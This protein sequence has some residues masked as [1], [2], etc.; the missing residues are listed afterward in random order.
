MKHLRLN[1]VAIWR[2]KP[3]D[4]LTVR[5]NPIGRAYEDN[6]IIKKTEKVAYRYAKNYEKG[7][8]KFCLF[9]FTY[10]ESVKAVEKFLDKTA[11]SITVAKIE[12]NI[13]TQDFDWLNIKY[14]ESK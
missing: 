6:K 12:E 5:A 8:N 1:E 4:E 2:A 14:K 9:V 10:D 7:K 11:K 3:L 13:K